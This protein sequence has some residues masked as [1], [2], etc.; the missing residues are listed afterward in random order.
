MLAARRSALAGGRTL[1]SVP[2]VRR[3]QPQR[4]SSVVV[5]A[6]KTPTKRKAPKNSGK[7]DKITGK[8]RLKGNQVCF[9]N[10]KSRKFQ[11]PNL[12]VRI[13]HR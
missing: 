2:S 5:Q 3:V 6:K 12:H 9:S 11:E 7:T 8:K 4:V 10:K 1:A 13:T